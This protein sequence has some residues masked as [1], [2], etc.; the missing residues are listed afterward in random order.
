MQIH[1]MNQSYIH[2]AASPNSSKTSLNQENP[3]SK[4]NTSPA[5]DTKMQEALTK[6]EDRDQEVKM[7]EAAHIAAGGGVVTGGASFTYQKGPNGKMY[8]VGGEV[9][10]D[11][12]KEQTHRATIAKMQKVKAAALAPSDPSPTDIKVASTAS[13]MESKARQ[14]IR[15]EEQELLRLHTSDEGYKNQNATTDKILSIE[16]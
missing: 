12:S 9:P 3:H 6:L 4:E 14:E 16:G 1:Q 5:Q 8:A 13:L 7:H 15:K 11:T 2:I 10:I